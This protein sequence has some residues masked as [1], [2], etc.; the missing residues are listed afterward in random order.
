MNPE[1]MDV[2][3]YMRE[4]GYDDEIAYWVW[5]ALD[6][7]AGRLHYISSRSDNPMKPYYRGGYKSYEKS[8]EK[9]DGF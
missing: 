5:G 6:A 9:I 8:E 3:G 7:H 1:P 4:L 2:F